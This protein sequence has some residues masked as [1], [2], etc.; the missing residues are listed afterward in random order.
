MADLKEKLSCLEKPI[1]ALMIDPLDKDAIEEAIKIWRRFDLIPKITKVYQVNI[2]NI[3]DDICTIMTSCDREKARGK[4]IEEVTDRF[5]EIN[6][7]NDEF[8]NEDE[9]DNDDRENKLR[10]IVLNNGATDLLNHL[11]KIETSNSWEE[12]YFRIEFEE[13]KVV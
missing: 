8:F 4:F 5:I 1:A 12:P 7:D 10:G 9:Q 13:V 3:D 2:W 6:L 11:F